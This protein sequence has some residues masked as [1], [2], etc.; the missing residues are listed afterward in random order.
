EQK[1]ANHVKSGYVI[2]LEP[3]D[4]HRVDVVMS[5]RI[6][7][8]QTKTGIGNAHCE[9]RDVV[10]DK[11]KHDQPAHHHVTGSKCCFH[12]LPIDVCLRSRTAV[13]DCDLDG[14]VNMNANRSEE[15][16]AD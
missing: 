11:R 15:E 6:G 9:M 14:R 8:E 5:E 10:N 2:I 7:F 3:I 1:E 4:H 12:I 16:Y 13:F